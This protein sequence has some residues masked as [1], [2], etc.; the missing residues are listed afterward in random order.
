MLV[1]DLV[2]FSQTSVQRPPMDPKTSGRCSE[3]VVVRMPFMY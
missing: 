1:L 2:Q 3:V